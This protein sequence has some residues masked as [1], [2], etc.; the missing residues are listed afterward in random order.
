VTTKNIYLIRHG[1][2]DFNKKGFLQ[3]SSIDASLNSKGQEQALAFYQ[4]YKHIKYNKIYT[5]VL[6]RSIESVKLFIRDGFVVEHY[7]ELNEINWG[8][9]EGKEISGNE[10]KTLKDLAITWKNG[11]YEAKIPGG[12]SPVEVAERLQK[13]INTIF[14]REEEKNI[15]I[16]LHGRALR[17]M[18][19]LLCKVPFKHME[20]YFHHNM[21][22]YLLKS[23]K[24]KLCRIIKS[25]DTEHLKTHTS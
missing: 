23:E 1:E 22:L 10:R 14:S 3:G 24:N 2:T 4:A 19:C 16:C 8:I 20:N 7:K 25:N 18:I 15:L 17:I 21:G 5:S 9:F 12:E 6:K 11:N 13:I